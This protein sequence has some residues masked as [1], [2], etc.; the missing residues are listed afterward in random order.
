M[1][2][3]AK[4]VKDTILNKCAGTFSLY[5]GYGMAGGNYV[6]FPQGVQIKDK[7]NAQRRCIKAVFQYADDSKLTYNYSTKTGNYTLKAE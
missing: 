3:I 7:R 5:A 6:R 2:T 1:T 4:Q